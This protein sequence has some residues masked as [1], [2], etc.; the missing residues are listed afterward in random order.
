V[1]L[2]CKRAFSLIELVVVLGLIAIL[3]GAFATNF[4][5]IDLGSRDDVPNFNGA[6]RC[7]RNL[8][9]A[10]GKPTVLCHSSGKFLIFDTFGQKLSEFECNLRDSAP[11]SNCIAKFDEF[12][13][14]TKFTVTCAGVEYFSDVLAGVLREKEK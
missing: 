8:S 4:H 6:I 14:F 11:R 10:T 3:V 7:A 13:F 1:K 5:G 9:I 2:A 12:G